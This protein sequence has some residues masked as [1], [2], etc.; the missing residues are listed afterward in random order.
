MVSHV[1]DNHV[2][3]G[4]LS[5]EL[6]QKKTSFKRELGLMSSHR[7]SHHRWMVFIRIPLKK[8]TPSRRQSDVVSSPRQSHHGWITVK[9]VLLK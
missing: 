1:I 5:G 8:V 6:N 4:Y 2:T 9:K 3:S 7:Q